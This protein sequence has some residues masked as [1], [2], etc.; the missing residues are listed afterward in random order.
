VRA[1]DPAGN[2]DATPASRSWTVVADTPTQGG[3]PPVFT[4]SGTG[5]LNLTLR[6]RKAQRLRARGGRLTL[7]ATCSA[8]CTLRL[9]G[10]VKLSRARLSSLTTRQAKAK[11]LKLRA[12]TFKL[13]A[14][15]TTNLRLA[16]SRRL[17]RKI[18][19]GLKQR[20][21]ASARLTGAVSGAGG[22]SGAGSVAIRLKR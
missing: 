18:L 9:S 14:G 17:A 7:S 6:A 2:T 3:N 10:K 4:P 1:T 20:R 5:T 11:S 12:K 22:A 19:A 21:R 8:D 16:V 13:A 15:K